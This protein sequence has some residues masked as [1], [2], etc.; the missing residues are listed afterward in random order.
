MKKKPKRRRKIIEHPASFLQ[1]LKQ[2]PPAP[3]QLDDTHRQLIELTIK[4]DWKNPY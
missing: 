1:Q 4:N 3:L 2:E